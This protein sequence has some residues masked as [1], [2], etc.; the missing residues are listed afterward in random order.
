MERRQSTR[1]P[2]KAPAFVSQDGK[3]IF[4]QIRD[5]S[6][7]GIFIDTPCPQVAGAQT[8]VSVY[9]QQGKRALSMTYPCA[10]ARISDT[11]IGCTS[12]YLEPETLLFISNLIHAE[13]V[14][15]QEFMRSFYSHLDEL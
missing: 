1:I 13:R 15:P 4:S 2:F 9:L 10:V 11:G 6:K 5:I 14:P 7:H 3:S 8:L 12:S